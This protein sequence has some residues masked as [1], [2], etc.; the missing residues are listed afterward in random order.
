M[1][2]DADGVAQRDFV[3][4]HLVQGARH[5]YHVGQWNLALVGAAEHGGDVAAHAHAIGGGAAEDRLEPG[6]RLVDAALVLVRLKASDAAVNTA[7]SST[8]TA[9]ARS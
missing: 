6:Q 7:T 5:P 3:T 4:A 1:G 8:P 2:A 9:R